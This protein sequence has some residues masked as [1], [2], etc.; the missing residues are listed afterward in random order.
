MESIRTAPSQAR[1]QLRRRERCED[2]RGQACRSTKCRE[3]QKGGHAFQEQ[4]R[5]WSKREGSGVW[6]DWATEGTGRAH[7]GRG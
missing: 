6:D 4:R 2:E 3:E 1:S 5:S 7:G